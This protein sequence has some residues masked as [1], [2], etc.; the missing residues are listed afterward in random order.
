MNINKVL[1]PVDGSDFSLQ[2]LPY[3]T[4]FLRPHETNI[5]LLYV[6][7]PPS[8]VQLGEPDNPD[9]TIY[10]DQ[11]A[12]SIEAGFVSSMQ[13]HIRYLT[14]TGFTVTTAVRFGDPATE[15]EQFIKD[16]KVDLVAMTT[17]GRTGLARV[18]LGSVAQH[19]I[20]RAAV[21]V[22]LYRSLTQT[23][24]TDGVEPREEKYTPP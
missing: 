19:I 2:I 10:A 12:A 17:H 8:M 5:V 24:Q 14:H 7:E 1:I 9:L 16:E 21:P 3:V 6:S 18:L 23:P 22:L 4:R 15:I 11:E 13:M 20:N